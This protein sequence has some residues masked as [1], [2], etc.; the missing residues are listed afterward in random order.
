MLAVLYLL[1][2]LCFGMSLVTLFIPDIK[3]LFTACSPSKNIVTLIPPIIFT[4][5]AG[6]VL[7]MILVAE[8]TYMATLGMSH[9]ISTPETCKRV[10]VLI[11][12]IVF[13]GLTALNISINIKRS[14]KL[15]SKS[16]FA[17]SALIPDFSNSVG[18]IIYYGICT[19]LFTAVAAWLMF[20][21]YNVEG[22]DLFAGVSTFSD[23]AP[24]TAMTSSFGVGFNYPTE[25]YHFSGDGI[26]YH[27]FF[28]YLCGTLQY[29]GFPIDWAINL[30]S[31]I[32]MVCAFELLGLIA[33]FF[34][35]RRASFILA[36]ILVLF[37]SSFN[38]FDY[39]EELTTM[40]YTY[41]EAIEVI[42][43][44]TVWYGNTPYDN[45]GIWAINVYPNQRHLMLGMSCILIFAIIMIPFVRRMCI[46]I[47]KAE[48][49]G[50]KL[51][52]F[53]FK[54]EAWLWRKDDPLNPLGIMILA[55]ILGMFMPFIHG[56]ALIGALLVLLGMAIL[57]ESR[58]VYACVAAVAVLSSYLQTKL[59]SG[60]ASNV[61]KF[62]YLPGFVV[63]DKTTLGITNYIIT[64]TGLTILIAVIYACYM[65]IRDISKG[66]PIYRSLLLICFLFPMIFAF[67]FQVSLE[68]L[69]N[70]KFIQFTLILCDIYVAGALSE[71]MH[72]PI[73]H[74]EKDLPPKVNNE[75]IS[76]PMYVF[77]QVMTILVALGLLIP[78][79]AT[80]ISEWYTYYNLNKNKAT[81]N[82][83]SGLTEWIVNNTDEKDVFLT[84]QWSLNRFFLAGR[85]AYYGWPYYAWSAGH[86][87]Y[88]RETIYFWLVTGCNDDYDEFVRYCRERGIKYVV[89]DWE[90]DGYSYPEGV[91]VHHDFFAEHLTQVAYFPDEGTIVYQVYE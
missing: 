74:K 44:G 8:V 65:L 91:W 32:S 87:T 80:G 45:W 49:F 72:L 3:R 86:D 15:E 21:T 57:S 16:A 1:M 78:L 69:A 9:V 73:K 52:T 42:K 36:P 29:L 62:H 38:F 64:V 71:L 61:V 5:P 6:M 7:G 25:Y 75:R 85:P 19:V 2:C 41:K 46:S 43:Q 76:F 30:P 31:I 11:A 68:M 82:I 14:E 4:V 37:R 63:E 27:F 12:F 79:T 77:V 67:N 89:D 58:L 13:I 50:D 23:L 10:G 28:Y 66:K 83:E 47:I 33:V 48:S 18:S 17:R 34:S 54:K 39:L 84:P 22:G 24:H 26:Q 70:H 60:S 59:F 40:G 53:F 56:S 20:Y 51:N 55:S 81:I 88:T 90:F 35:R